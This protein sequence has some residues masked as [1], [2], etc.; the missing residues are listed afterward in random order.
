M[1]TEDFSSESTN[2]NVQN[3]PSRAEVCMNQSARLAQSA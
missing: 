3:L 2:K 1:E